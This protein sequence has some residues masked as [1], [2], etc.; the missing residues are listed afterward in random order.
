MHVVYSLQDSRTDRQ[1]C[2]KIVVTYCVRKHG[3]VLGLFGSEPKNNNGL[4]AGI[5]VSVQSLIITLSSA[6]N[7]KVPVCLLSNFIF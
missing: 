2:K 7:Y 1:T 6:L 4:N 3:A 5:C